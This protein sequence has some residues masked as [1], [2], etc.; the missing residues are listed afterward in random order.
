METLNDYLWEVVANSSKCNECALCHA[1]DSC[2]FA[3]GCIMDDFSF[4]TKEEHE[5]ECISEEP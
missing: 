3:Y 1:D 5:D 2:F 4:F